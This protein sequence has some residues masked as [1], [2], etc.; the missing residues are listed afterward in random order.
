MAVESKGVARHIL[1]GRMF[2]DTMILEALDEL[3]VTGK[4]TIR[5]TGYTRR[6]KDDP[7]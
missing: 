3:R 4:I 6:T 2:E 7:R 1:K 5:S